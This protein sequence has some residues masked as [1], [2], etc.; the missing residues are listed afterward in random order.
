MDSCGLGCTASLQKIQK[1]DFIKPGNILH[2]FEILKKY[3]ILITWC[4]SKKTVVDTVRL[5]TYSS[6]SKNANCTSVQ[7]A[8]YFKSAIVKLIHLLKQCRRRWQAP[9]VRLSSADTNEHRRREADIEFL[10]LSLFE[11]IC[12][13]IVDGFL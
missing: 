3:W 6:Y 7:W 10:C 11:G 13:V 2:F 8:V 12:I 5:Y 4:A 9:K 1:I